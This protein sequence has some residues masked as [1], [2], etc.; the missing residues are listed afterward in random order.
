MRA[1]LRFLAI[2]IFYHAEF[3]L[4]GSEVKAGSRK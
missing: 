1:C 2:G 4:V 3:G